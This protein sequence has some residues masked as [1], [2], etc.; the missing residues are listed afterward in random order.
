MIMIETNMLRKVFGP[1]EA[2]KGVS[3]RVEKGEV[4]GFLGPNGAG[5]STVMRMLTCFLPPTSGTASI[6]QHD[7]LT[8]SMEARKLIGYLPES[9]PLYV[10]M[11]PTSFL[12]FIGEMRGFR[13]AELNKAVERAIEMCWLRNVREQPIETLSKGYQRR[14]GLAQALLHNPPVLILDEPTDGLDPNQKHE[15]HTLIRQMASEKAI[16]L[17]THI[18][19]EVEAVCTRAIIIAGGRIVADGTPGDLMR[20]SRYHGAV[21]L[22]LSAP[23][24]QVDVAALEKVEG[25]RE[26][27][28]IESPNGQILFTVFPQ[29]G[30]S[31]AH[32][33]AVL[34]AERGWQIE[35]LTVESGNLTEVFREITTKEVAR[36]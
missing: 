3:F 35:E 16:V 7:I 8:H 31:V 12:Q 22:S 27:E 21:R 24:G 30:R 5:K 29:P 36:T 17:S 9:N 10:D 4:L 28:R 6:G 2:V 13:G 11:T 1:I 14:V 34:A 18:L 23:T 15:V 20:Q 33:L 26:V 32:G 25:V 19:E